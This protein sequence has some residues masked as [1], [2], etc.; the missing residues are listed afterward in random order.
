VGLTPT[1]KRRLSTAHT[2]S[3]HRNSQSSMADNDPVD[4]ALMAE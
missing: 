4:S 2:Q 3:G 1:G